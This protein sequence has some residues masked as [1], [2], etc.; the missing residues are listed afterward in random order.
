MKRLF[1]YSAEFFFFGCELPNS[2]TSFFLLLACASTNQNIIFFSRYFYCSVIIH[3]NDSTSLNNNNNNNNKRGKIC[4]CI[5]T[6]KNTMEDLIFKLLALIDSVVELY[7][8]KLIKPFLQF[9][10]K[11]YNAL[12]K[13]L[14][15]VLDD[16]KSKIPDWFTANFITYLRTVLI[17]PTLLFLAWQYTI[18]PS[19]IV[20]LVD[21]GDFLDGVV[22]RY[23]VDIKKQ[24][25][26]ELARKEKK[27]SSGS[28]SPTHSD[29]ESFGT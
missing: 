25:E 15:Q 13:V 14:R 27:S 12:N 7:L 8:A 24:R 10:E 1:Q 23:W 26:E 3:P 6:T 22:A 21:F 11:F 18:L 29:D 5:Y 19:F 17:I 16:N 4:I 9:H 28:S 2:R 20:I